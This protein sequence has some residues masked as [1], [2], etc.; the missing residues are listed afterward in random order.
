MWVNVVG[1]YS[2]EECASKG[3]T[4]SSVQ[5]GGDKELLKCMFWWFTGG[6]TAVQ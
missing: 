3:N 4:L 5:D 2:K 1:I 6:V